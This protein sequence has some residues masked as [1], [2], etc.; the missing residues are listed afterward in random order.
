ML[1]MAGFV[2]IR[3]Y[4]LRTRSSSGPQIGQLFCP[5]SL[6]WV[7]ACRSAG[8]QIRSRQAATEQ[9]EGHSSH[10]PRVVGFNAI[11]ER[12]QQKT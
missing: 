9:Q 4:L 11:E 3:G 8:R 1:I 2:G 12:L 10:R 7:D 5:Q 6:N